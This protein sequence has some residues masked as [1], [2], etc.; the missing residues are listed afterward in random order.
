MY[1]LRSHKK[2]AKMGSYSSSY[3]TFTVH[4]VNIDRGQFKFMEHML[5]YPCFVLKL[6]LME[7]HKIPLSTYFI[8]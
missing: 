4:L 1:I 3:L 7:L 2:Q 8:I 5:I 6:I